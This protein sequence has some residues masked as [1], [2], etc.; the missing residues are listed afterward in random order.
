[1]HKLLMAW[2]KYIL[3]MQNVVFFILTFGVYFNLRLVVLVN[4]MLIRMVILT[5]GPCLDRYMNLWVCAY[6][7]YFGCLSGF[8]IPVALCGSP[9]SLSRVSV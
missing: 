7:T 3:A 6:T 2:L 9:R 8:L 5:R 1:M 4:K